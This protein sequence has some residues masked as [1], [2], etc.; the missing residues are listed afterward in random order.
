[1]ISS[2]PQLQSDD[3]VQNQ[4]S[5]NIVGPFNQLLKNPIVQG[6]ILTNQTLVIGSNVLKHG[7]GR[8][9]QGWIVTDVNGVAS[10]Y[11]S[12]PFNAATLTLTSSA[13]VTASLYVF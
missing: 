11:R 3:R 1:M 6:N 8:T 10:I 12:A 2:I 13:A 7:L 4:T 5:Q 9:L